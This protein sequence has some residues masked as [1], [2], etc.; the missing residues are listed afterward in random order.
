M[1]RRLRR[2][3]GGRLLQSTLTNAGEPRSVQSARVTANFFDLLG[4]APAVGRGFRAA[5]TAVGG[6]GVAVL[7]HDLWQGVFGGDPSI[8]VS[9]DT[10]TDP[11]RHPAVHRVP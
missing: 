2:R 9:S 4:V 1:P 10:Q 3:R 8:L 5:D 6:P 7:A 11:R